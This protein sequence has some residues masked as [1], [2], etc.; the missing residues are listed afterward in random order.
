MKK[1]FQASAI[2]LFAGLFASCGSDAPKAEVIQVT[3]SNTRGGQVMKFKNAEIS[4]QA[5]DIIAINAKAAAAKA[6]ADDVAFV[7]NLF[8]GLQ[9][10]ENAA[11]MLDVAVTLSEDK[12][13]DGTFVFALDV[14]EAK[15]LTLELFDEEGFEL[16]GANNL[17]VNQGKNYK[18]IN[19]KALNDGQYIMRLRDKEGKE[20]TQKFSIESQK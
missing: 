14:Q 6:E 8:N 12:V 15:A 4:L 18:A 16:A 10:A 20:L 17:D 1:L 11:A 5:K 13:T 9:S 3:D 2:V 19:V 7:A